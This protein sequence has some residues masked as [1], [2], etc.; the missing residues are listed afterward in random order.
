[1]E[2]IYLYIVHVRGFSSEEYVSA[3][4]KLVIV[5]SLC[6]PVVRLCLSELLFARPAGNVIER[7]FQG[8]T[9]YEQA[10]ATGKAPERRQ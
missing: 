1:M 2:L 7:L 4:R 3:V 10:L 8:G 9:Q 5:R 6:L